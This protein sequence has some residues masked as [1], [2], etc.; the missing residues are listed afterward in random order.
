MA[1]NQSGYPIGAAVGGLLIATS[2][3]S[4]VTVAVV[5]ACLGTIL[6]ILLLPRSPQPTAIA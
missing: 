6:A 5:M 1:L 4:A 2:I 3:D